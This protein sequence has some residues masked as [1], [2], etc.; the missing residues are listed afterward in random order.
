V[1]F[2]SRMTARAEVLIDQLS[3]D[4]QYFTDDYALD[5]S[6]VFQWSWLVDPVSGVTLE[7]QMA[8]VK[9]L[10]TETAQLDLKAGNRMRF[11]GVDFRVAG[12]L[13]NDAGVTVV[14]L[15]RLDS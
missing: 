13:P 4:G 5:V 1:S 3:E 7:R 14:E 8:K 15:A 6:G 2:H 12:L 11:R 10:T 9:M